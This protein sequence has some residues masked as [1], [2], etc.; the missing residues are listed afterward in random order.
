MDNSGE[1]VKSMHASAVKANE[2]LSLLQTAFTR[3]S[4]G[5]LTECRE[6]LVYIRKA[7]TESTIK[8]AELLRSNQDL[9]PYLSIPNAL[10][11]MGD[12]I[13]KLVGIIQK[14]NREAVLFSDRAIS[15]ITFLLQKLA[16]ILKTIAD[17]LIIN[18]PV[19]IRHVEESGAEIEN[20]TLEYATL[21]EERL[22]EGLCHPIAS[23]LFLAMLNS[24]HDI[25]WDAKE[26]ASKFAQQG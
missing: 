20:K 15:E 3:N 13:E 25:A 14:K 2:C 26:I 5:P 8:I 10:L 6:K 1:L 4:S 19:L 11:M 23:P 9:K 24:I 18:N 12:H 21:H 16:E 17:L 22:I 7:E